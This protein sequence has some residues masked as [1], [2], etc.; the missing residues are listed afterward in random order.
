MSEALRF[1]FVVSRYGET[2]LG[3]AEAHCR[4]VAERLAARGHDVRVL[5]TCSRSYRTWSNE[6]PAGASELHGVRVERHPV[7]LGR[8]RPLDEITK[9]VA[10]RL[11]GSRRLGQLWAW[12]Q[13]PYAPGLLQRVRE[14]GRDRDAVVFFSLLLL[15][16][17]LGLKQARERSVLVPL[18]HDE[19]PTYTRVAREALSQP[20]AIIANTEEELE[21]IR[22]IVAGPMPPAA[23][24]ALGLD[25]PAPRDPSW[26][27]P[28][29]APYLLVIGRLAKSRPMLR[30]WHA[31]Q[32]M[33]GLPPLEL[34]HGEREPWSEVRLV[35]VGERS[36][37]YE[38][39]RNVIQL[40]FVDESLRSQLLW[41]STA[42][43]NPSRYE[44]LSLV[45]L[46]AWQCSVPVAVNARC[47]VTVG[48]C[49]RSGGGVVLDFDRP[50]EGARQIAVGLRASEERKRMAEGG[51]RYTEQRYRWDRVL[52]AYEVVARSLREGVELESSLRGWESGAR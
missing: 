25:S 28:T 8:V 26:E 51:R 43:V 15:Q 19:P 4:E 24:V 44:S 2:I 20:R 11:R 33:G 46:E 39:V 50:E 14:E 29:R 48:Q 12:M 27:P 32:S 37:I 10:S 35:T 18:V 52:D 21:R 42:L 16:T 1:T 49:R 22:S 23:I 13:G 36:K 7:R 31:L 9:R 17:F 41:N 3:G 40:D 5:T 6:L 47:D 30:V 34:A 38:G 45:L